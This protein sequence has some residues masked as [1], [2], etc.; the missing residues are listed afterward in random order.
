MSNCCPICGGK[1]F[2]AEGDCISC[3][4]RITD[5]EF[6]E[7]LVE[8]LSNM[9]PAEMLAISGVYEVLSEELNNEVLHN[10]YCKKCPI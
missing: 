6:Y 5:D 9:S 10:I 4:S 7:E 1:S 8:V 2:D 3:V